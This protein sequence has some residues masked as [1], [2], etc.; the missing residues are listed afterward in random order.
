ME[1]RFKGWVLEQ[2]LYAEKRIL[3]YGDLVILKYSNNT[4]DYRSTE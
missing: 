4:A 2:V 1:A 3:G